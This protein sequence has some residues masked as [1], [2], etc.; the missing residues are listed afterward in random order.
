MVMNLQPP[1]YAWFGL[2]IYVITADVILISF[3]RRG[4]DGFYTMST[5]FRSGL[6]HPIH[7]WPL[8][9]AWTLLTLHLFDFFF[10]EKIRQYDPVRLVGGR[11]ATRRSRKESG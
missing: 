1:H 3:E 9:M 11:V 6:A 4:K 5:A 8:I 2:T 10:P 7:R